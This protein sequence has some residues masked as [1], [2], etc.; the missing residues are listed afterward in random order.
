VIDAYQPLKE[1]GNDSKSRGMDAGRKNDGLLT[2]AEYA[3]K[4][5]VQDRWVRKTSRE[6]DRGPLTQ[7]RQQGGCVLSPWNVRSSFK[8]KLKTGSRKR[9][10]PTACP[11]P[12]RVHGN[13]RYNKPQTNGDPEGK[14][15]PQPFTGGGRPKKV[16]GCRLWFSIGASQQGVQ[17]KHY[18][19]KCLG[20]IEGRMS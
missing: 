14:D 15:W 16:Q 17:L 1:D 6:M 9:W 12:S 4:D 5:C 19:G 13:R 7:V 3:Y 10:A 11:R 20:T 8:F 18:G 2:A